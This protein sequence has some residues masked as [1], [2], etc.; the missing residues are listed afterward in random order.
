MEQ[1]E[2]IATLEAQTENLIGWQNTQNGCLGRLESKLDGLHKAIIGLMGG[3]ITSLVL[4]IINL[5][6]KG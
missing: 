1:A 6:T 3:M 4:L 5:I 2:R